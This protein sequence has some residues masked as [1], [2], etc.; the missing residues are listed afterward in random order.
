MMQKL[1][2]SIADISISIR[3]VL[4]KNPDHIM[5]SYRPFIHEKSPD[6]ELHL[7]QGMPQNLTG[8]KIFDCPPNWTLYRQEGRVIIKIFEHLSGLSRCLLIPSAMG[9]CELF[10]ADKPGPFTDPFYGPTMELLLV[11]YLAYKKN[12]VIIHACGI[13]RKGRGILF[14]GESSAG[15]ST[16]AAL[17][18]K[19]RNVE[20]LS[21]DRIVLK[22]EGNHFFMY[23]TPWHG[24]ASFA[25]P[26]GVKLEHVFFLTQGGKN[27]VRKIK[28]IDPVSRFLTS[29]F[30]PYWDSQGVQDALELF[31]LLAT[32]VPCREFIFTPMKEA[33]YC[34]EEII[35]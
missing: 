2:I 8:K 3:G 4:Q 6:I 9:K 20:I 26:G 15:K 1:S 19:E 25:S 17:W 14:V 23:G 33:L 18:D 30:P 21:D 22:R 34:I 28:G 24:D 16:I 11:H 35:N 12:G 7:H 13:N 32:Q 5:P 29:S 27:V 10:F 31:T